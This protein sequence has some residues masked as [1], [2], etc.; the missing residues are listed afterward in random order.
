LSI[1][2]D[3]TKVPPDANRI[4]LGAALSNTQG[5]NET[6]SVADSLNV[7]TAPVATPEPCTFLSL[8]CGLMLLGMSLR[9]RSAHARG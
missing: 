1:G 3:S 6:F 5:G 9:L 2:V 8:C 7:D 4:G